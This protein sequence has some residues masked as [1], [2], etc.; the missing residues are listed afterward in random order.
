MHYVSKIVIDSIVNRH[1]FITK[2]RIINPM[3]DVNVKELTTLYAD[4]YGYGYAHEGHTDTV[5]NLYAE[6]CTELAR[7]GVNLTRSV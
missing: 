6:V 1:Y 2:D 5:D 4:S 7:R 3:D